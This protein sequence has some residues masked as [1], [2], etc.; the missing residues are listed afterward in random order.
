MVTTRGEAVNVEA[1]F[2]SGCIDYLTKPIDSL[3]LL[4]KVRDCL[5][6]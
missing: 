1:G 4:S 5:G 6:E 2:E 3:V